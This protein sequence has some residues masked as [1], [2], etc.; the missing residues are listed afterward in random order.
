MG[1]EEVRTLE[2]SFLPAEIAVTYA[3]V[4]IVVARH[5]VGICGVI[6]TG[7]VAPEGRVVA[8]RGV[9]SARIAAVIGTYKE[10]SD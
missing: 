7:A 9:I 2:V 1:T 4:R 8:A 5:V 6:D 3:S 10:E